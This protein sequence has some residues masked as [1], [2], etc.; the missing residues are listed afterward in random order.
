MAHKDPEKAREYYKEW[1]EKNREKHKEY[2]R[3]WYIKKAKKKDPNYKFP[4]KGLDAYHDYETHHQLA[5][6]SGIRTEREWTECFQRGFMP[7][8]IYSD[9]SRAF[10]RK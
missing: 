10:R 6:C 3:E 7:D 4:S 2:Q 9:P 1:R 8:G 5:I